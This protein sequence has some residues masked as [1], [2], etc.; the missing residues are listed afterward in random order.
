MHS[1]D[2]NKE[3]NILLKDDAPF[4]VSHKWVE[5]S[6]DL[7]D[8][9]PEDD[10]LLKKEDSHESA[11]GPTRTPPSSPPPLFGVAQFGLD[12]MDV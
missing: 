2:L 1:L 3:Q 6:L 7:Q 4:V 5:D 9:L 11:R 10:F 8:R 12:V